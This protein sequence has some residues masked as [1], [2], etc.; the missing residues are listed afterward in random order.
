[1]TKKLQSG[2]ETIFLWFGSVTA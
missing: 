2:E 1:M